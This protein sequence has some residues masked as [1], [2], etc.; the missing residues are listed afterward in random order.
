MGTF[1]DSFLIATIASIGVILGAAYMLWLY[2][3]VIFGKLTN[4]E[5]MKVKDLDISE[6]IMLLSLAIPVLFFGFYP[7]PIMKTIEISVKDLIEMYN[8]NLNL[9]LLK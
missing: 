8:N 6:I 9:Y 7:E 3:R 4:H 2:R 1:Q 5:L